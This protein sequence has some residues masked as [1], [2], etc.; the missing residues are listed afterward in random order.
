MC[1]IDFMFF[2]RFD[3][4]CEQN[5]FEALDLE[6]MFR[7]LKSRESRLW[8][9]T[10]KRSFDFFLKEERIVNALNLKELHRFEFLIG[11]EDT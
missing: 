3:F 11:P 4:Y 2:E 6:T 5:S 1:Y 9:W 8:H 7:F 10:L